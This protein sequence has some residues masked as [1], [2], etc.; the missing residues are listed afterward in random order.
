MHKILDL[1]AI[2]KIVPEFGQKI[3][4]EVVRQVQE[5]FRS[6]LIESGGKLNIIITEGLFSTFPGTTI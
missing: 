1:P 5:D 6:D 3:I 4:S 2:K